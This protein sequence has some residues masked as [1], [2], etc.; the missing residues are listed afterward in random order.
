MKIRF[1]QQ[2]VKMMCRLVS[3][4]GLTAAALAVAGEIPKEAGRQVGAYNSWTSTRE[5]RALGKELVDKGNS[6]YVRWAIHDGN[7]VNGPTINSG[8]LAFHY[9]TGAPLISWPKGA[10]A[11]RYIHSGVFY[12]AAEV[13]D[14]MGNTI[15][16][17]SDNYRR[18]QRETSIDLSHWYA[19]MPLPRY[20]NL[21]QPGSL[22]IP[23][24]YGISE[25]VGEDGVPNTG[26]AGEG[27]NILQRDE[28]FNRNDELDLSMQNTVG[29]FATSHRK[30]TWP[31]DWPVGSFDDDD[32]KEGDTR[33]SLRAGRWNGAFGPYVRATQESFYVMDDR[34]NDEYTYYPFDDKRP[35]PDGRRGLGF[36]VTV[37]DYQWV[38][39]L[40]EDIMISTYDIVN[41]GKDLDKCVVGMYIDPDMGGSLSGDDAAFDKLED[42]TY[43]W[44]ASMLSEEG[45]PMGYFGFAFLESPGLPFDGI[46]NDQDLLT[47]ESQNN[48]IDDD[49]DWQ[50]YH[51]V[52]ANGIWD[53]EDKNRNGRL[54][55]GEDSNGNG[56]LDY[57]PLNDDTG[58]DGLSPESDEYI[59]PDKNGS[60]GNGRP[61][62]GEPN[63]E[64]TDNAESDQVGLTSFY[65][66][67][68]DDTMADDEK[69]WVTEIMPNTFAVRPG[70]QRDIA[71]S[72]GSGYVG[73]TN[74]AKSHHYAIALL[75]GNDEA[76][77][78]RNKRTMQVIYD[79]DYNFSKP[80][81]TPLL[82][83]M[84]GDKKVYLNW[85][86]AAEYS[87]DP[88][89]GSDFEAYYIYR[90]TDAAF[91]E[92]KTITDGFGNPLLFK[93]M[94]IYDIKD[95]L[96]GIHPVRLGSELGS[97]S[98]LGVSY[99]MGTDSGLRHSFVDTTVTNGRTY[100]Y[101][102]VSIDKGYT[103]EF[104]PS[105]SDR[106]GLLSI[107]PTECSATIQT[108]LLGRAIWADKNTAII[109]PRERPAGWTQPALDKSGIQ[110]IQGNGS[111]SIG[112]KV[113]N[114]LAVQSDHTYRVKFA[115]DGYYESI[116]SL[117]TGNTR[118]ISLHSA[119]GGNGLALFSVEN[120]N[121]NEAMAE[122]IYDGVQV[123]MNNLETAIDTSYWSAGTS[124][125]SISD[126]TQRLSGIA[127]PRD[128]E[129]RIIGADAY[130]P[131][132]IATTTNFTVWDVTDPAASFQVD[133]R[134]TESKTSTA[135]TRGMLKNGCRVILINNLTEK[136]QTWKWDF[137]YPANADTNRMTLPQNGDILKVI[138]AKPFDRHDVF[139]F[140]MRGND[141]DQA[142]I[143]TDLE[144]IYTVPD[145]YIAV[146]ALERKVINQEEG[147][148]DRRIDFVNLPPECHISIYT[149]SGKL[150][151]ELDHR[152]D[153]TMSRKSWD[154]RTKDGLEIAHGVYFY[155]VDAPGIGVKRGK[156]AVIK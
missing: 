59:G 1:K 10:R 135:A 139:E 120:P 154:L 23:E 48:G 80:P 140:T 79:N 93:P 114:P 76:D 144:K 99:N 85:D 117:F 46:D 142:K 109:I 28:D 9:V 115:D 73:F 105:I 133:Y 130:K 102:V 149:A 124:V 151:R 52:N 43:A 71:W 4:I 26:D 6:K 7:L 108:D 21:D 19:F 40:S 33:A 72:Y 41:N 24:V 96:K 116:D 128:Y 87:K 45:W 31:R 68:V 131:V 38:A 156:L 119:M 13:K 15:H 11:V 91:G 47:D 89:Y 18:G 78:R 118:L 86:D 137:V 81:R 67:D 138:T 129:I 95:G 101:A 110:H 37:R 100:Y 121:T 127:L 61:D 36:T 22:E 123:I 70:Y 54:D 146:S 141:I 74:G 66:R 153:A 69:Y 132:N 60:E 152:G 112:I 56:R 148:G 55:D 77:I 122:F 145:P 29:W 104:Y 30:E 57:E 17:V 53:T 16:I 14:A 83:A 65:L 42:I 3:W 126:V 106:E 90:S 2:Q 94:A 125:L 64:F 39:R 35:W 97:E 62:R 32:R 50:G 88:I 82:T 8:L 134:F 27:D 111:G 107:S 136:K 143:V 5:A 51:D 113:I 147:R 98:D 84:A 150:V 92:I 63:F 25:D 155:V 49:G 58:T 12:A 20:F 75:F 44:S 34:E 103:P